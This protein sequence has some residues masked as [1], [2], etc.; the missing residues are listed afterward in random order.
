MFGDEL[1]TASVRPDFDGS[2]PL[3]AI[4][5]QSLADHGYEVDVGRADQYRLPA[6]ASAK[7]ADVHAI[8]WG[9]CIAEG[10]IYVVDEN[11]RVIGT[12]GE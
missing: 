10:P 8:E 6:P 12:V 2:L 1:M 11:G 5:I 9:D 4:T 3:S 7:L